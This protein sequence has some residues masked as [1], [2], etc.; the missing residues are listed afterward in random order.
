MALQGY[1]YQPCPQ[2][3]SNP[4]PQYMSWPWITPDSRRHGYLKQREWDSWAHKPG[5]TH[6]SLVHNP[7]R[8]VVLY[9]YYQ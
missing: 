4:Q 2:W 6:L 3:D 9:A 5:L 1:A 8:S 7:G